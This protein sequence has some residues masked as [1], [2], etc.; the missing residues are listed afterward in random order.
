MAKIKYV[1][2][3]MVPF[4]VTPGKPGNPDTKK[5]GIPPKV[6]DVMPSDRVM[7][8]PEDGETKFLLE[9]KAIVKA[10]E[11]DDVKPVRIPGPKKTEAPAAPT[12]LEAPAAPAV[13]L[14]AISDMTK[15]EIAA[16]LTQ[17]EIKFNGEDNKPVLVEML[18]K[19]RAEEAGDDEDLV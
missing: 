1:A 14:K 16:E 8:D 12:N 3:H 9:A 15:A 4:T 11:K 13:G 18:E 10:Q 6:F 19:A 2:L 5:K 7:L 17:R